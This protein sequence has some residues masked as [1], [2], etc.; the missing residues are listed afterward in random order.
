VSR[1]LAVAGLALRE[2]WISFRLLFV[3]GLLLLAA[4]PAAIVPVPSGD[5]LASVTDHIQRFAVGLAAGL[6]LAAGVAAG[7]ISAERQRGTAGWL[8]SRA[9]PRATIVAG[10]FAAFAVVTLLGIGP[11]AVLAWLSLGP[12]GEVVDPVAFAVTVAAAWGVGLAALALGLLLGSLL[13]TLPAMLLGGALTAALLVPAVTISIGLPLVTPPAPGAPFAILADLADASRPISDS[14]RAG[15]A[16]LAA[17][18]LLLL[19][20]SA[21]M[22]RADL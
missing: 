12:L 21:V 16:A 2:L 13:P 8:V 20:A 3:M 11:A 1:F 19:L 4:L 5:P 10:W 22:G 6:A 14:V 7:T 9:V 15:G 18:A 17:S